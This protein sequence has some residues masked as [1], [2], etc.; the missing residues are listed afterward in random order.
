MIMEGSRRSK[1]HRPTFC[2][3]ALLRRAV[4]AA[5]ANVE[6]MPGEGVEVEVFLGAPGRYPQNIHTRRMSGLRRKKG[7]T[8]FP[9]RAWQHLQTKRF[10]TTAVLDVDLGAAPRIKDGDCLVVDEASAEHGGVASATALAPTTR[11]AL[12]AT[13]HDSIELCLARGV[14]GINQSIRGG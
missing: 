2:C 10:L 11:T 8:D 5:S 1:P 12:T 13:R 4:S 14:G 6:F 9:P 3:P 7:C